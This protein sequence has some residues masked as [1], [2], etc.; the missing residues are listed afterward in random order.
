MV[1]STHRRPL[2]LFQ[3][4]RELLF[5]YRV[6]RVLYLPDD[7]S[8]KNKLMEGGRGGKQSG[9]SLLQAIMKL[10]V[11]GREGCWR[12]TTYHDVDERESTGRAEVGCGGL[13]TPYPFSGVLWSF[14]NFPLL[15]CLCDATRLDHIVVC[16][17]FD[18]QIRGCFSVLPLCHSFGQTCV[19]ELLS[20]KQTQVHEACFCRH[21]ESPVWMP[22]LWKW[23]LR[24]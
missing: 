21:A 15:G 5:I 6:L 1:E 13:G 12:E 2:L 24:W 9:L 23:I 4:S 3:R 18:L 14:V 20:S 22:P 10:L 17:F 16:D 8:L 11:D 19:I 7:G